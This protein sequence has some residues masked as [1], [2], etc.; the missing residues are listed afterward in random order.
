[1]NKKYTTRSETLADCPPLITWPTVLESL[2][3]E[4]HRELFNSRCKAVEMYINGYPTFEIEKT[5]GIT[6]SSISLLVNKCTKNSSDG[7]IMGYRALLPFSHSKEYERSAEQSYKFP[8]AQGGLSGVFVQ[9]LKK[10]P[11]VKA[12][13]DQYILKKNSKEMNVHE[14]RIR[15]KDLHK[16]F[17]SLLKKNEVSENQWPFN[18]K[19]LGFKTIQKYLDQTLDDSFNRTVSTRE[20]QV[21][22][23]HL[24][25]STGHSKFLT[26]EE[27]YQVVQLDAYSINAFFTAK[28]QTPENFTTDVQL[29]RVWLIAMIELISGA[30]LAQNIVYRSEV[31]ADD[32]MQVIRKAV[33]PPERLKLTIPGLAYPESGGMPNEIFPECNGALWGSIMLDGALAHLSNTIHQ[34]ARKRL[35]FSINWGPVAHFE[36]RPDIE[37]YFARISKDIFMRLPSTTGSKPGSGRADK[38]EEKA[39]SY[40]IRADEV[41][42]LVSVYTAQHNET[43]SGGTFYNSPIEVLRHYIEENKEHF[44]LGKLFMNA[45]PQSILMPL[46]RTAIVR[47][48]RESG[49][50]PYVQLYGVRYTNPVLASTSGL[51][52][53]KLTLEFDENDVSHCKAFLIDGGEIGILKALGNWGNNKHSL[54]TRNAINSL[55]TKKILIVSAQQNPI[56]AYLDYLSVRNKS[57]SKSKPIINPRAATEATRVSKETGL[58]LKIIGKELQQHKNQKNINELRK[59]RPQLINKPMPDL[60][61][62]LKGKN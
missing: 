28:F 49:R 1:V 3:K 45:G 25:V 48:G 58:P 7:R 14:K 5:T 44:L 23:A 47:G 37:R 11:E 40:K 33:N 59:A 52:G 22:S 20:E 51:I 36:R 39:V 62:L 17:L 2:V 12:K 43:P 18:T 41:E 24:A 10:Y 50:R 60:N 13:L 19:Y 27:P 35:G 9:T 8:E 15:A 34:R 4:K 46:V 30:I 21:S 54:K 26:F 38:A 42:E 61:A 56:Q 16:N 6:R 31:S 57:K 55:I 53:K 32:V 29:E